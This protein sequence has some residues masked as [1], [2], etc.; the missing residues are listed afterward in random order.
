MAIVALKDSTFR[1]ALYYS[2]FRFYAYRIQ[3]DEDE[4]A[5]HPRFQPV[6]ALKEDP[7][8]QKFKKTKT[9]VNDTKMTTDDG[10]RIVVTH[11]PLR[12]DFYAKDKLVW[13]GH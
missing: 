13:I 4:G 7:K 10:H 6:D 9:T 12:I 5:L 11:N 8:Q 3:I 1:Y 2:I